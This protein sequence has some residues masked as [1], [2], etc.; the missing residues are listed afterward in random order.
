[1]KPDPGQLASADP[2][3]G[4]LLRR[5]QH[6]QIFMVAPAAGA[7]TLVAILAVAHLRIWAALVIGLAAVTSVLAYL[8]ARHW[9]HRI[10]RHLQNPPAPEICLGRVCACP[11]RL[12]PALPGQHYLDL[13]AMTPSMDAAARVLARVPLIPGQHLP[14][15]WQQGDPVTVFGS[16]RPG[17]VI[18]AVAAGTILLPAGRAR[19]P[20]RDF[21]LVN[22]GQPVVEAYGPHHGLA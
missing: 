18:V 15:G 11:S 16:P 7:V 4:Y 1:V 13:L 12:D 17:R 14:A 21:A 2:W 5:C 10:T 22:A 8:R 6:A 9:T 20:L 3:A 19:W